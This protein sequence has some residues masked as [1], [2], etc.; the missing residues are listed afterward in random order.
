M[1]QDT[2]PS[3]ESL[4]QILCGASD[5]DPALTAPCL[6]LIRQAAGARPVDA[7]INAFQELEARGDISEAAVR[8]D[9]LGVPS[10]AATA[11][12]VI[13]A[14]FAG[15]VPD[16]GGKSW[17]FAAPEHY[18]STPGDTLVE[19]LANTLADNPRPIAATFGTEIAE[20]MID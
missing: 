5:L 4:S 18:F 7:L 20:T 16:P 15:G 6:E 14:W 8:R 12:L 19:L 2:L 3:F 10:L 13:M 9:I 17:K 11:R 1:T